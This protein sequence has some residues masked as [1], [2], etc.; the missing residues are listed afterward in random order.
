[1]KT[2][3]V[4][5]I[6]K[7]NEVDDFVI[8]CVFNNGEYR[9][10]DFRNLF[11]KWSG[12]DIDQLKEAE[13]FQKVILENGTLTWPEIR[14]KITLKSGRTFDVAYD[15]SP[16]VLFEESEINEEEE[17]RLNVGPMLK[18]A[19]K[20]AG[21]T[22]DELAAKIGTTKHYLSR[23]ENNKSDIEVRTLRR[24]VEVGLGKRLAIID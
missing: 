3:K 9:I 6:I 19:R 24:I 18:K 11:K 17:A 14:K 2:N 22:Q 12:E 13:V 8:S 15:L 20:E 23:I 21:L 5:R 1:M 10:I 7:I 16:S 4:P